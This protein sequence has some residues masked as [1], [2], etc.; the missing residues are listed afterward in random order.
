MS[1]RAWA[2]EDRGCSPSL[3]GMDGMDGCF[4]PS[5][6]FLFPSLTHPL[7]HLERAEGLVQQPFQARPHRQAG[8]RPLG[9]LLQ[10]LDQ[11]RVRQHGP[12]R[13]HEELAVQVDGRAVR[14][15]GLHPVH[16]PIRSAAPSVVGAAQ[17]VRG[18]VLDGLEAD[19]GVLL[20]LD[21]GVVELLRRGGGGRK[22]MGDEENEG[23]N[24]VGAFGTFG[25]AGE[26]PFWWEHS[27][28]FHAPTAPP[29][30]TKRPHTLSVQNRCVSLSS[31]H[32]HSPGG[33]PRPAR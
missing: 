18:G 13:Q 19:D 7:S 3:E 26:V 1:V 4:A 31:T 2:C 32:V 29:Y 10:D 12:V 33:R 27:F 14:A 16:R 5:H 20:L 21:E 15:P 28:S 22:R 8:P 30:Q 9:M 24:S 6:L 17:G 11:A 25:T 23:R